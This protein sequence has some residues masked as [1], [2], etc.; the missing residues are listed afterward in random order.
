[1][2]IASLVV[3][4]GLAP[5]AVNPMFGPPAHALDTLQALNPARVV[6]EGAAWR[7]LTCLFL[8]AGLLHLAMNAT[9][10]L[11]FGLRLEYAWGR[12]A[13]VALLLGAGLLGSVYSAVLL[14]D[15][16][17]VGASGALMGVLGATVAV[18]AMAWHEGG[19]EDKAARRGALISAVVMAAMVAVFSLVPFVDWAAHLFGFLGGA[20]LA[21]AFYGQQAC[22]PGGNAHDGAA[23]ESA[24]WSNASASAAPAV[25]TWATAWS[26]TSAAPAG[27][28]AGGRRPGTWAEP[29]QSFC[30]R[31]T[32]PACS[33][34]RVAGALLYVIV[35]VAGVLALALK[36][37]PNRAG[38]NY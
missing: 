35:L 27:I 3:G 1:M 37:Q 6:Y 32:A 15:A 11:R 8:H 12:G 7:L 5:S 13:Y 31:C 2:L 20:L 22:P 4:G 19:D 9:M 23:A 33:R 26:R 25:G 29:K 21:F 36:T 28:G 30:G 14:P 34:R 10:A 38:L 24:A 18:L 17:S 16:L